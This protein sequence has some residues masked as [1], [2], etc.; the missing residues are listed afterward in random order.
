[1]EYKWYQLNGFL[2]SGASATSAQL[3]AQG[4]YLSHLIQWL[5][6]F[7]FNST[8]LELYQ[9]NLPLSVFHFSQQQVL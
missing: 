6:P 1:M 9:K 3:R 7:I 8:E 4:L 5:K 2:V